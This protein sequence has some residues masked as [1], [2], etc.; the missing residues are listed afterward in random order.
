M[1][2]LPKQTAD[3]VTFTEEILNGKLH[4]FV[5]STFL[6]LDDLEQV[7][8]L[9][10]ITYRRSHPE[11]LLGKGVL[12][13]CSKFTGEH[14]C[15]I[16]ISIKLQSSFMEITLRHGCSP[17]NFLHIFRTP[18]LKNTSGRLLLNLTTT[19][20][21]KNENQHKADI[22]LVYYDYN[23][24]KWVKIFNNVRKIFGLYDFHWKS[25]FL[26]IRVRYFHVNLG[27]YNYF[28]SRTSSSRI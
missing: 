5:I 3:L 13:T 25:R 18:F 27:E 16:A 2:S 23:S 1:W 22:F 19:T 17:V 10:I 24:T 12:K 9:A 14:R 4:F 8:R 6:V 28:D 20:T 7:D 26:S 21:T 11:V 15:Q